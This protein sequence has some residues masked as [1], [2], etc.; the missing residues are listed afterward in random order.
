MLI[1]R[2]LKIFFYYLGVIV[3]EVNFGEVYFSS[4]KTLPSNN[5]N[6]KFLAEIN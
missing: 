1:T 4:D 2:I 6:F 3:G 5:S